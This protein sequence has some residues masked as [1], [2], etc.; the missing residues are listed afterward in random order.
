MIPLKLLLLTT[1]KG[2]NKIKESGFPS[3]RKQ[4]W[5][6]QW[7]RGKLNHVAQNSGF[8][9]LVLSSFRLKLQ[10]SIRS[11]RENNREIDAYSSPGLAANHLLSYERESTL[12]FIWGPHFT[13]SDCARWGIK[14]KVNLT[15]AAGSPFVFLLAGLLSIS[16]DQ[17]ENAVMEWTR[18]IL[19]SSPHPVPSF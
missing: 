8:G 9:F 18:P 5:K 6:S 15:L 14:P 1:S 11:Q 10:V 4:E 19:I 3:I 7:E 2:S 12:S 16:G 13:S 17:E